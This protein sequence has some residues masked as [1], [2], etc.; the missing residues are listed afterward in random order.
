MSKDKDIFVCQNCGYQS[1][2]WLGKCPDCSSWGTI[3]EKSGSSSSGEGG[4]ADFNKEGAKP[5][6]FKDLKGKEVA[7]IKSSIDEL[8]C[9]LGGGVVRGS[10]VLLGGEPGI[11]KSTLLL[12]MAARLS[13]SRDSVLYISGEESGNQIRMRGERLNLSPEELYV[14]GETNL[15]AIFEWVDKLDPS[16]IIVDSIQTIFSR[17][18]SSSPGSVT[19]VREATTRF[20]FLAKNKDIPVFLIGHVTKDGSIA[21]PKAMEHIVDTVLYFEGDSNHSYRIIRAV[22]NRFGPANEL[23]L[24]NMSSRGLREIKNPSA[25]LIEERTENEPGSSVLCSMEG[26]RPMLVEVQSLVSATN[27]GTAKRMAL[28]IDYNRVSLLLAVLEKKMGF[29][30]AGCDVFV[31]AAGGIAIGEPAADLCIISA[32][33]SSFKDRPLRSDTVTFGEV[34]LSG[35]I[36]NVP[37]TKTRIKESVSMGFKRCVVPSGVDK[38]VRKESI[39]IIEVDNIRE[40]LEELV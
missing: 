20:L 21:G 23:A 27:Y 29:S 17:D 19:Q 32:I 35:E 39:D 28:G 33:T 4:F 24:F 36:R 30:L 38:E 16:V 26:S 9:V 13:A 18:V 14:L 7:R 5:V 1:Q 40:A 37:H 10:L 2:K 11:G 3:K 25:A 8:D 31:N 15:E 34:G 6:P 12:Q 22:K